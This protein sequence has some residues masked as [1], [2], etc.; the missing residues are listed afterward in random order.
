MVLL[1]SPTAAPGVA[2]DAI[3]LVVD[4]DGTL[5]RTDSLIES[6]F[7]L[8][9]AKPG[10]LFALP[11]W[12]MRGRA[13]F[14]QRLSAAA[15]PDVHTMPYRTQLVAFLREQKAH[16]RYLVLATGADDRVAQEIARVTGL[17]DLVMASD[18]ITNL[19]GECKRDRL[20][21]R[22]GL[23]RFDYVG[24][25]RRDLPMWSAARNALVVSHSRRLQK[26][27]AE[28]TPVEQIFAER[29]AGW[30]DLLH[31]MRVHHW[32]KNLLVFLPLAAA[33]P[34]LQW[35]PIGR[36]L[37]AFAAFSLCASSVYLLNDLLDLPTD[38]IHPN[39]KSRKLASGQMAPLQALV[40]WPLLLVAALLLGVYLSVWCMAV[41]AAYFLVMLAY[42]LR[43]KD[44]PLLDVSLLAGGYAMRVVMGALAASIALS[45]WLAVFCLLLFFSFALI[46]R[47]AELLLSESV[48]GVAGAHA[49]GYLL[50]DKMI[51]VAQGIASG[52]LAVLVLALYMNTE[53]IHRFYA[54][55]DLFGVLCVLLFYWINYMWLMASR[56][57]VGHDPVVFAFKDRVSR[58]LVASMGLVAAAAV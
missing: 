45:V 41:L 43:L 31:A 55:R 10:L 6:L 23:R 53:I 5:L 49:R 12:L 9:R 2:S 20:V 37:I 47:Y 40:L 57:R 25:G 16:G 38:R 19:V 18:G 27:I 22:F 44:L 52:Y 32:V 26:V 51:L 14:K 17:F 35:S 30:L 24:N 7:V 11:L 36:S 1:T 34:G 42:S 21:A 58:W 4:L 48:S 54:R 50:S 33:H 15:I 46:K 3:P 28:T 39:N 13:S 29:G 56:G 8:A